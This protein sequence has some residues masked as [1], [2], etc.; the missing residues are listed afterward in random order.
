MWK[1]EFQWAFEHG[2]AKVRC[3]CTKCAGRGY[4]VLLGTIQDLPYLNGRN[5]LFRVWKGPGQQMA[6]M[7]NGQKKLRPLRCNR[8]WMKVSTQGNFQMTFSHHQTTNKLVQ[9][10]MTWIQILPLRELGM[11]QDVCEIMEELAHAP[12]NMHG[13]FD[14]DGGG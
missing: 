12:E 9:Q 3:P 4:P 10:F 1:R 8:Q 14:V 6:L 11:L 2:V 5:P 7:K 13:Q